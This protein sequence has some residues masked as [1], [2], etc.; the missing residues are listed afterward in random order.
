MQWTLRYPYGDVGPNYSALLPMAHDLDAVLAWFNLRLTANQ[1]S[2]ATLSTVRALMDVFGITSA[3][4]DEAK[5]NMLATVCF[6]IT[7][8]PEYLV[9]K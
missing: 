5:L 8:S 9:Q 7:V 3:S 4:A 1:L 2:T 6:L